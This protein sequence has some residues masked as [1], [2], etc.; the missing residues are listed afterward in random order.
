VARGSAR[1]GRLGVGLAVG[2]LA[3]SLAVDL[4]LASLV[5]F[6]GDRLFL[7]P[8]TAL[9]GSLLWVTRLRPFVAA[10]ALGLGVLWLAAAFTPL[11]GRLAAGLVRADPL[12][13]GDAVLVLGSRVQ[14]DGDPTP[15]AESR[16]LRGLELLAEGR[17]AR[18]VV[19]EQPWPVGPYAPLARGLMERLGLRHELVAV[20]P[21]R[22]THDEAVAAAR[23]CRERGWKRL[24]VVSSPTHTRR[25]CRTAEAQGIEVVC[26]PAVETRLDL[27][28]LDR[29]GERLELFGQVLHER[30]GYWAYRRRGWV[31]D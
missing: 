11:S 13:S 15:E 10:G 30:V 22:N 9:A 3:G 20:G 24:L 6:W 18:L 14:R 7:V 19:T 26:V 4:D 23:L 17:A 8:L 12:R 16:L 5:S 28:T 1:A 2:A 31:V 27:E 29:P 21:A 25:A